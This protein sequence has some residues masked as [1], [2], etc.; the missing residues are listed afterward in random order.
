VAGFLFFGL[1]GSKKRSKIWTTLGCLA[2][3]ATI[4]MMVGCGSSS[5]TT[6]SSGGGTT[7]TD[8]AAG[9]YTVT[10]TGTD[11]TTASITA[12]TTFTLTVN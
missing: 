7:S 5:G 3:V 9:T 4:G 6:K 12:S 10:L 11:T 1:R 8:V 2:L